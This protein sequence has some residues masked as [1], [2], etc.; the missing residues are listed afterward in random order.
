MIT[1]LDLLFARRGHSVV[2]QIIETELAIRSVSNVAGVLLPAHIRFLIVLNATNSE[3][4]KIVERTHPFG[5]A[6]CQIIVHRDQMRAAS[7]QGIQIERQR[8]DQSFAFARRHF[9]DPAAMQN[10]PADQL[11]VEVHH[12]P[13]HRLIADAEGLLS[14][15]QTSRSV[16]HGR[17]RFR[18]NLIEPPRLLLRI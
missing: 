3:P 10:H 7:S 11:H 8:R 4:K 12:V 9:R 14:I 16:L 13:R 1:A 5:I 15:F 18:Q 2:A 6:A 17:E